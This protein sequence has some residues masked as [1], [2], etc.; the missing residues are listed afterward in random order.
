MASAPRHSSNIEGD[1][2]FFTQ[3]ASQASNLWESFA[4][5]VAPIE[6]PVVRFTVCHR[7]FPRL[8]IACARVCVYIYVC[9]CVLA[10]IA[11]FRHL[12]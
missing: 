4:N 7:L 9:M 2:G 12:L 1:T 5:F 10:L 11:T 8:F 3:M 6:T